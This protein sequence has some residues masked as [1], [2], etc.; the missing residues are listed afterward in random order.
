MDK[1]RE[2]IL[3]V[4]TRIF[5]RFGFYKT[6]MDEIARS[7]HK[8]KGSLYY[9]FTSKEDLFTEVVALELNNLK[10][11][12]AMVVTDPELKATEKYKKYLLTRM[13]VL[14]Q[15]ANYQETLKADFF[16][17]F[18]FLDHLRTDLDNW[19][20]GQLKTIIKQGIEEGTFAD[21]S[22]KIDAL[23]DVFIMVLKGLEIPFFLQDKYDEYSPY[24]DDLI[25]I[26][27][28]GMAA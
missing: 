15:S 20:K 6:S 19:E 9:H 28:K 11:E 5:S 12:L 13:S 2:K 21:Q 1:T 25:N 17:H 14:K 26:I 24:F 3:T 10:K 27:V 7:A 8:A 4:A 23:L 18:E 16:E 22:G